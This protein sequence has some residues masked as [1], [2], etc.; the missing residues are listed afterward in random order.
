MK[1]Y[2][3]AAEQGNATAQYNI[4]VCYDNGYGVTKDY[5]EA[6]KWYRKAAAQGYDSA[7]DRL[8]KLGYSE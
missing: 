2:R 5:A 4:G 6:V 1:W 7:K 3:K 8:K